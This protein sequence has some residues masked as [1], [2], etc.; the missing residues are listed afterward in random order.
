M[1]WLGMLVLL[2]CHTPFWVLFLWSL[3][4]SENE[5]CNLKYIDFDSEINFHAANL[6]ISKIDS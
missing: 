2:N 6:L 5:I 3:T 1:P 4:E